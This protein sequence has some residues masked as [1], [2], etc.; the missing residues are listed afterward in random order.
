MI[1]SCCLPFPNRLANGMLVA[2]A[3]AAEDLPAD[4]IA[5]GI[6][7]RLRLT[8]LVLLVV[9]P[10]FPAP[11]AAA[12]AFGAAVLLRAT[13]MRPL[14]ILLLL[15]LT[16]PMRFKPALVVAAALQLPLPLSCPGAAAAAGGGEALLWLLFHCCCC[17]CCCCFLGLPI[18]RTG[19]GLCLPFP[20]AA[21]ADRPTGLLGLPMLPLLLLWTSP[22]LFPRGE[23]GADPA[24]RHSG[25]VGLLL[26]PLLLM[27]CAAALASA[28]ARALSMP[29]SVGALGLYMQGM[30]FAS[31]LARD[32]AHCFAD[33]A[34]R[35]AAAS[36]AETVSS[37][38]ALLAAAGNESCSAAA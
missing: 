19:L 4:V 31:W 13:A 38:A 5:T 7:L 6:G 23:L 20:A 12:T 14:A 36:A 35:A 28:A 21:A 30:G 26:L 16:G 9:G 25:V 22:L 18:C 1:N 11:T 29:G 8:L 27:L 15:L 2:A 3:V 33:S 10:C 32:A 37:V 24:G 17:C 34:R